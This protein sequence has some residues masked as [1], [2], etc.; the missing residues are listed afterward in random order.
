[1]NHF[2]H[3]QINPDDVSAS[4]G[5]RQ[6]YESASDICSISIRPPP[7]VSVG[8]SMCFGLRTDFVRRCGKPDRKAHWRPPSGR[9]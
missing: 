3:D 4:H 1:M 8:K 6:G 7:G 2:G 5:N 9:K